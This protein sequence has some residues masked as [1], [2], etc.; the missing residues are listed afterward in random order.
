MVAFLAHLRPHRDP[1]VLTTA[2]GLMKG[3]NRQFPTALSEMFN[4]SVREARTDVRRLGFKPVTG[5]TYQGLGV[6]NVTES[7][8]LSVATLAC[9]LT[10]AIYFKHS[11]NIFPSDGGIFFHWFTNAQRIEHGRIVTLDE[12]KQ[13]KATSSPL[14]RNGKDLTDQ[15]DYRYSVDA[16]GTLHLLRVTFGEVFGFVTIFS[17]AAGRIELMAG[18][19]DNLVG[20]DTDAFWLINTN[21]V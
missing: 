15:F 21:H 14:K 18:R 13:F 1:S 6:A 17:Q 11:G 5:Q 4:K 12:A 20:K 8:H 3:V 10:K 19:V 2:K 16:A 7:M 9:K